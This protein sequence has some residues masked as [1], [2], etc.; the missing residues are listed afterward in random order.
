MT[1]SSKLS[2]GFTPSTQKKGRDYFQRGAVKI[3]EGDASFVSGQIV[4]SDIYTASMTVEADTVTG[5][6]SCPYVEQNLEPC[7]HLWALLLAAEQ[8]G[9]LRDAAA[10]ENP[11]F[12]L[13][14]EM[15]AE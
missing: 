5:W 12:E 2:I 13:D 4:G 15:L 10:L 8:R 6:C 9:H 14:E 11:Y 7:K 1:L 3:E